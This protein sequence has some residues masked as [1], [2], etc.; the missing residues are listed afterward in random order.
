MANLLKDAKDVFVNGGAE[1]LRAAVADVEPVRSSEVA[2][3]PS[4]EEKPD[5]L[6]SRQFHHD[7]PP[8]KPLPVFMLGDKVISSVGNVTN[9]QALPKAGKSAVVAALIAAALNG[10]RQG[11]DT[12]GFSAEN[13]AG[14]ALIHIDTEQS[15]YDHDQLV[16]RALK[17]ARVDEPPPWLLSYC[18]T[19]LSIAERKR[20]L[21]DALAV[22]ES[23]HGGVFAILIDGIADLTVSPNDD[24]ESFALV[25]RLQGTAMRYRCATLTVLHENPS[26]DNGK[27]RGHLGSQLERKA[28]TNLRLAKDANGITS[29]WAERAR[30]CH[31]PKEEAVCFQWS[32][33]AGMHVSCGTAGEIRASAKSAKALKESE[34]CFGANEVLSYSALVS[35]IEE[36]LTLA[37]RTAKLRVNQWLAEGILTK[38][39]NGYRLKF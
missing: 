28:E 12:L 9:I 3:M 38:S 18:I 16:R 30:H 21:D 14:R 22:A 6:T 34:A 35:A 31:L 24:A 26:S 13:P 29:I 4:I 11:P 39:A 5:L 1:A 15:A 8:G 17:R 19:D 33:A 27:T 25:E 36:A 20:A 37:N 2:G 7:N 23:V 10:N 32:D